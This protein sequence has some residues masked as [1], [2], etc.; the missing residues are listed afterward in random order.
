MALIL[1]TFKFLIGFVLAIALLAAGG[2]AASRYLITKMTSPPPKPI[3]AN[4]KPTQIAQKPSPSPTPA[5]SPKPTPSPTPTLPPGAYEARVTWPDGLI[6]RDGP[7]AD[8]GSIGGIAYNVKVT[9]LEESSDQA[10]QK[11]RVGDGSQEGWI[12]AG[13]LDRID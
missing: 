3:F 5:A 2:F 6:L 9:V 8:A 12:K 1:N 4:D 11:V 10:W 13:N 7:G